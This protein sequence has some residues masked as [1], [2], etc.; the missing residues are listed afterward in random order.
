ME[1]QLGPPGEEAARDI[2][3]Y[4]ATQQG[5]VS[6]SEQ[7]LVA[8]RSDKCDRCHGATAGQPAAAVPCIRGQD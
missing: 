4:Y 6:Q 5:R 2:A 8:R 3:A 1:R 7:N